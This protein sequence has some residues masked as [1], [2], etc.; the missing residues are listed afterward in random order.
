MNEMDYIWGYPRELIAM[1]AMVLWG[2]IWSLIAII[3]SRNDI[4]NR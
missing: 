1:G 2:L 3:I 4:S